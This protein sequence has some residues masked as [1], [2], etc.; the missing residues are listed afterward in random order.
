[1]N[2]IA[3][4]FFLV[5]RLSLALLSIVAAGGLVARY[6]GVLPAGVLVGC[7]CLV[8]QILDVAL[9]RNYWD[10]WEEFWKYPGGH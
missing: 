8:V 5:I 3:F 2:S 7:V 1:M 4:A 6:T 10:R 9:A